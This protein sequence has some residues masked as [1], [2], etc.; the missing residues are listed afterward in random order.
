[1]GVAYNANP[2]INGGTPPFNLSLVVGALPPG[3]NLVGEAIAGTLTSTK[4]SRFTVRVTDN[5][6]A[7]V[8]QRFRIAAVGAVNI[9]NSSLPTAAWGETT[10]PV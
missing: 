3:L 2:N 6:G 10:M 7:S 9:G 5:V 8:M 1:M 4:T